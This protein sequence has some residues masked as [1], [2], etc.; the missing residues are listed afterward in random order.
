[1]PLT[2]VRGWRPA[3][4]LDRLSVNTTS[5]VVYQLKGPFHD[6]T[7][8]I[9]FSPQDFIARIAALAPR[10]RVTLTRYHGVFA[11]NSPFRQLI[12]PASNTSPRRKTRTSPDDQPTEKHTPNRHPAEMTEPPTAPL[13]WAQRLNRVFNIDITR[14]P[15][16]GGQ[17][18]LIADVTDPVLIR[19][20]LDH[21]N[22]QAPPRLPP[23]RAKPHQTL[24]DLFAERCTAAG[25][26]RP[27]APA[28][29]T[30]V[31]PSRLY[32]NILN[33]RAKSENSPS[34][35]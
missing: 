8:H 5:Q 3:L 32:N 28:S 23:R 19:K 33:Q 31:S 29:L 27:C 16:C 30:S 4:C 22:S 13:S 11:P 7:T 17:V 2:P 12:V 6:G 18:R 1:V 34:F 9:L 20:I 35:A 21:V 14:C 10:P 26:R 15:L 24:P 25:N